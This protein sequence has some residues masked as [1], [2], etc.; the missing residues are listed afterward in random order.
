MDIDQT[1]ATTKT[2]T[3]A[4]H[5]RATGSEEE[6]VVAEPLLA[7]RAGRAE[8]VHLLFGRDDGV[9]LGAAVLTRAAGGWRVQWESAVAGCD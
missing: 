8:D 6:L 2:W 7:F 9:A 3:V 5:E 4:W 1:G